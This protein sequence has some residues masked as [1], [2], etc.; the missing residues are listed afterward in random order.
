MQSSPEI[1][2][3]LDTARSEWIR[4]ENLLKEIE[5]LRHELAIPSV[6][7]LRYAGR[8]LVDGLAELKKGDATGAEQEFLQAIHHCRS[9]RQDAADAAIFFLN[10]SLDAAEMTYGSDALIR[11]NPNIRQFRLELYRLNEMAQEARANRLI[12]SEIY[13]KIEEILPGLIELSGTLNVPPDVDARK[14]LSWIP[15]IGFASASVAVVPILWIIGTY[16]S[17]HELSTSVEVILALFAAAAGLV[18]SIR[19]K[20][21]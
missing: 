4:A 16:G 6:N 21:R 20:A 12:R 10:S 2:A 1:D 5:R 14:R 3:H 9:A 19:R 7:E 15:V 8:R 17:F 13:D 18:S 11:V